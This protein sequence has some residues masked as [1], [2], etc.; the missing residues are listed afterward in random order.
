MSSLRS[1]R[2]VTHLHEA[3]DESN[4][5]VHTR[6]D[7]IVPVKNYSPFY[8]T[9]RSFTFTFLLQSVHIVHIIII[10]FL[11][12]HPVLFELYLS[13]MSSHSRPRS[14]EQEEARSDQRPARQK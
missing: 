9:N 10:I 12:G 2:L 8:E 7:C 3:S 11:V 4:T 6:L 5:L 13:L 1:H 14:Q